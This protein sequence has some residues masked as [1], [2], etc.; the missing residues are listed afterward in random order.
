MDGVDGDALQH[1]T[2]IGILGGGLQA[3]AVNL[4]LLIAQKLTFLGIL[5]GVLLS[6]R[7]EMKA[8]PAEC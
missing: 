2:I 6:K 4:D 5:S 7:S 8:H 1:T 3:V